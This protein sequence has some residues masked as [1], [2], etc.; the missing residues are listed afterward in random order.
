M[1]SRAGV[2]LIAFFL[3]ASPA[4][5]QWVTVPEYR[6][7]QGRGAYAD[8]MARTK[9]PHRT[10]EETT[11]I[12]ET[13]HQMNS[14]VRNRYGSGTS[15]YNASYGGWGR[16][17]VLLEPKP[18][19][20][21]NVAAAVPQS[22]RGMSYKLYMLDQQRDWNNEPAYVLDEW[23]AYLSS[24]QHNVE[25]G[26][27]NYGDMQQMMEMM[28]YSFHLLAVVEHRKLKQ[29]TWAYD[30]KHLRALVKYQAERTIRLYLLGKKHRAGDMASSHAWLY[31]LQ[32]AKD[33]DIVRRWLIYIYGKAWCSRALGIR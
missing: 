23:S 25:T 1:F 24:A 18:V 15:Q 28:G 20:L 22:L 32:S 4:A 33:A 5:A 29:P 6:T 9:Q 27:G 2:K 17:Y 3:L 26:A 10:G 12:H 30:T 14:E 31:N 21:A 16:S 8:V 19:T 13:T 7:P 11:R